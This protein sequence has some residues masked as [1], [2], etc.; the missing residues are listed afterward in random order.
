MAKIRSAGTSRRRALRDEV[1]PDETPW[2]GENEKGWFRAPRTLPL[3]MALLGSKT[4][5]G[6][7]DPTPV[8][9]ELLARHLDGGVIQMANDEEHAFAAGYAGYRGV[10]SWRERMRVLE[11]AG[12]IRIRRMGVKHFAY[13]LLVHPSVFIAKLN[14]AGKIDPEWLEAYRH[15]QFETGEVG[16]EPEDETAQA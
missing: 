5:S 13:V 3:I 14:A 4:V 10:R 11:E 15:R 6:N 8:Y 7:T 16:I 2:T 1:W 9:L 12:I